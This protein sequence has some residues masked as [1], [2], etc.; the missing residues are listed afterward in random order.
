[1]GPGEWIALAALFATLAGG[2]LA[3]YVRMRLRLASMSERLRGLEA[4]FERR[5]RRIA[6]MHRKLSRLLSEL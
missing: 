6:R 1:M 5:G 3:A 2:C 4:K